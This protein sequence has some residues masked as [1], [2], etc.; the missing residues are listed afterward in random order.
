MSYNKS[1]ILILLK[2]N[3]E[4]DKETPSGKKMD[5]LIQKIRL[6]RGI[7]PYHLFALEKSFKR[8][9]DGDLEKARELFKST[10]QSIQNQ[11]IMG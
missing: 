5:E 1:I 3:K 9:E 4:L 6:K 11:Y 10:N 8:F 2:I 7:K